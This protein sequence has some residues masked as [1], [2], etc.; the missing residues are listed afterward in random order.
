MIAPIEFQYTKIRYAIAPA[1]SR[2]QIAYRQRATR[3]QM[4]GGSRMHDDD[5][6]DL[7]YAES[8]PD[9]GRRFFNHTRRQ[10]YEAAKHGLI[11]TVRM[12]R[13]LWA[14]P[15]VLKARLTADQ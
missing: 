8:V 4:S 15:R 6:E 2:A 5:D 3:N 10:S 12:G 9:T 14:L 11:P 7:P 13:R 1:V